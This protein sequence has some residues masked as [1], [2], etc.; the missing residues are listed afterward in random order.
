VIREPITVDLG[1]VFGS[2]ER[3]LVVHDATVVEREDAFAAA[4]PSLGE[5]ADA[6][7]R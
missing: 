3:V 6:V 2:I 7:D 1:L 4:E 5:D